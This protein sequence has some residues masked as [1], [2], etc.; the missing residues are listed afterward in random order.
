[1]LVFPVR[2]RVDAGSNINHSHL[3]MKSLVG[4]TI[5]H[6]RI[7]EILGSGPMST[8]YKARDLKLERYAALKFLSPQHTVD[9]SE[10]ERLIQEAK[11]TSALEHPN[12]CTIYEIDEVEGQVFIAMAFYEGQTLEVRLSRGPMSISDAVEIITAVSQGVAK[13]HEK[14]I[15]HRD[16]KPANIM[17]TTDEV[18]KIL[19][20]GIAKLIYQKSKTKSGIIMG[21]P[22]YL[23]PEQAKGDNIGPYTD[24]WALGIMFYEMLS[25]DLPFSGDTDISLI[26]SI[27]NDRPIPLAQFNEEIPQRFEGFIHR[28][29]EK[30]PANRFQSVSEMLT[31]LQNLSEDRA[32]FSTV[33]M[34]A[35]DLKLEVT[36]SIGV[37]PFLDMSPNKDQ[38]YFCDGLTEEIISTLSRVEGLRV[39]SRMSSF[40]FKGK[41]FDLRQIGQQLNVRS[42]LE[43]SIRK[44][45]KRVRISV[46]LTNISDGFLLWSEQFERE[47]K[48]IF[49]IQDEISQAIVKTLRIK[50]IG[51]QE[52]TLY[53]NY[54]DNVEAYS[55]YLKGR[56]HW[57]KRTAD[58]LKKGIEHF[59]QAIEKDPQYAPAFA[60]LADTYIILGL[61]GTL[62]PKFVMPKAKA[63][64]VK[65]LEI[66]RDLA[67]AHASLGCIQSVYDWDWK[68]AE[69][70]FQKAIE[71]NP[72][73]AIAHHW[74][75][76][77]Y[78]TPHGRFDE[79][80]KEIEIALD[81]DPISLVINTTVGL[82]H[83]YAGQYDDATSIFLKTLEVEPNFAMA[84]FFLGQTYTRKQMFEAAL[85]EFEAANKL[86]GG[87]TNMQATYGM[88]SALA[89]EKD[90]AL[91]ILNRL[92]DELKE[93]YVSAYDLA[94]IHAGLGDN[95]EALHWLQQALAEHSYLLIY[96][97]VDPV[98]ENLR[99]D[100]RFKKIQAEMKFA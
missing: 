50:L 94:M 88:A 62:V 99:N 84:H 83:Y 75:A 67:E 34:K 21:T 76:I 14:G 59:N 4:K 7:E 79:A 74:Y 32:D 52:K 37:L 42:V 38:E 93:K 15:V 58:A 77:N 98:L 48:D 86:F 47:I 20:F 89:G 25:G 46:Q 51:Q 12:I 40:Q 2:S 96:L 19:D 41:E 72:N 53:K 10:T 61:Y 44:A 23:A 73:Y 8:V 22:G 92:N 31:E 91:E 29:I 68:G 30:E 45:G 24:I 71:L 17:I 56:Y 63:A 80:I 28:L 55:D 27:V 3:D 16:L 100:K 57:N 39:V 60:G 18:V 81:L 87:S 1:V 90:K 66:D 82:V 78:L 95:N 85:T 13:A 54:T 33:R 26:Y 97:N 43:G 64:A 5:S 49:Q 69:E 70:Q 6:Y 65:A 36:P 11:T 9:D 35:S